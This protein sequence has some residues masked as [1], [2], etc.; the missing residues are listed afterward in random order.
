MAY[1]KKNIKVNGLDCWTLFDAGSKNTY[2]LKDVAGLLLQKRLENSRPIAL[3]RKIH[4]V[5]RG[6]Y[7]VA[8]VEGYPVEIDA[9]IIDEIGYDEDGKRIDI[10]FGALTMQKRGIRVIS[11]EERLDMNRYPK[12]FIEF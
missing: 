10:I 3:G 12:E 8:I 6:R 2:I 11:D 7:L 1:V 4:Q 5:T 9:Y